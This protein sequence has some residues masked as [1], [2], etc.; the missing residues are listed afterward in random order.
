MKQSTVCHLQYS[1][2]LHLQSQYHGTFFPGGQELFMC[3]WNN[4][5]QLGLG[6]TQDRSV[7]CHVQG[8]SSVRQVSCGWNHTLVITGNIQSVSNMLSSLTAHE[9]RNLCPLWEVTQVYKIPWFVRVFISLIVKEILYQGVV[10]GVV[11]ELKKLFCNMF[12]QGF[13]EGLTKYASVIVTP[14]LLKN[15]VIIY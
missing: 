1:I 13:V 12:S 2:F 9:F 5:G 8:L 6:D 14:H 3:G 10:W 4:K 7:L 15:L 11:Y